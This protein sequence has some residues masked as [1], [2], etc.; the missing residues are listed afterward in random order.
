MYVWAMYFVIQNA[1][2]SAMK[3]YLP[4]KPVKRGFKVWVVAES[5]SGY[6]LDLQVYVGKEGNESEYG[7][8]ERV[9]LNLT[10]QYRGEEYH[11]F[12]DNFFS[13][14]RLFLTLQSQSLYA[15]GTVRPHR[16]NFP[17]D[18]RGVRF[19]AGEHRF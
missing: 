14:P 19:Q 2:R 17:P 7:L 8:G 4:L 15:C 3:Q 5:S 10:E 12:C 13:S 16:L 11:I 1:G 9:V 18:L 6:F